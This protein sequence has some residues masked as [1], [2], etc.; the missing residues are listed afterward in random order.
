LVRRL[1]PFAELVAFE[2]VARRQSFTL[3]AQELGLTQS[4]VSHRVRRLEQHFGRRL[5]RRLNPGLVLTDVGAALLPELVEALDGLAR[6]GRGPERVLRVAAASALCTWWLA[7]RLSGF[8]AQRPGVSIELVPIGADAAS[9]PE[10]DVRILWLGADEDRRGASEAS[11]FHEHVFPVCSPRLLNDERMPRS[12]DALRSM[13]LLHK[14]T[15][16]TGEWSWQVWL[17][18]FGIDLKVQQSG[19][20]RFADMGLVLS[21]AVDGSGVA[22]ARSLLVHAALK[23]GRLVAPFAGVEPMVSTKKHVARWRSGMARDRDINAFVSW[24][25]SE[26]AQTLNE[27]DRLIASTAAGVGR[28]P[29]RALAS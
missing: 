27:V 9:I 22:L 5:L 15:H 4:A 8:V 7:G 16:A 24:L 3:A 23:S 20:L 19:E 21:A 26:A 17:D 12:P 14:A 6:L 10:V 2:A 1:P 11:L 25:T 29:G 18:R 13:T 28:D